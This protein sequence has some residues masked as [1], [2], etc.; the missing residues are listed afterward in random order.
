MEN[1]LTGN[2]HVTSVRLRWGQAKRLRESGQP[3]A[4]IS[5]AIRR[6]RRGDFEIDRSA[7]S[8]KGEELVVVPYYGHAL[9]LTSHEVRLALDK[10]FATRDAWLEGEIQRAKKDAETQWARL[11]ARG[12]FIVEQ[13]E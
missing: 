5:Y 9:T 1:N 12:P 6:L 8:Q 13:A 11:Q 2:K 10:H 7:D 3:S 4:V